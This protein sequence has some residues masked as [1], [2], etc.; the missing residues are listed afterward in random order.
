M[1]LGS[2]VRTCLLTHFILFSL[3]KN[4]KSCGDERSHR[5][6]A[7]SPVTNLPGASAR[8]ISVNFSLDRLL[9]NNILLMVCFILTIVS[10]ISV[11]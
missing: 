7:G 8:S 1:I 9:H 11:K 4:S 5:S 2:G 10:K 6:R 3:L